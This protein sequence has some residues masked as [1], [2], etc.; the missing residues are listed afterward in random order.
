MKASAFRPSTALQRTLLATLAGAALA[1]SS[2]PALGIRIPDLDPAAIARGNAFA[3]TA[4]N[5]SA[6][7]YNPAGITQLPDQ[8][9]QLGVNLVSLSDTHTSPGGQKFDTRDQLHALPEFYYTFSSRQLPLS[10]GLGIYTPFGLGL[11][12]PDNVNFRQLALKGEMDYVTFNPVI[13]W[14]IND[15]I[16][17]GAGPMF[18]YGNTTLSQGITPPGVGPAGNRI[19][20]QGDDWNV[21]F[22][23]GVRWQ[24]NDQHAVGIVY[25]A[26]NEMNFEGTTTASLGPVPS[27]DASAKFKFPQI[28]TVGYSFRPTPHWNLEVNLD[29]TDWN[30]LNTVN[31]NQAVTGTVAR[32]FNWQ[33]SFLY[34]FGVSYLFTGNWTVSGGYIYSENSVPSEWFNPAIPDSDRHVF[35]AGV[36]KRFDRLNL[37]AAFQYAYGPT[38]TIR[39]TTIP[40]VLANGDYEFNS[41][42]L[43]LSAGY[44]F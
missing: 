32:P 44:R 30:S 17:L 40:G 33:S 7:H 16:S 29:W 31:F 39:N 10:L 41:F 1:P 8:Q 11:E 2:L 25:R 5:P 24:I 34:E 22:N 21:G 23:A 14:K 37:A 18:N 13:A 20:F 6:I 12:W 27:Q 43:S 9:V 15:R 4:D 36:S 26:E 42:S 19:E 35:S 28:I 38:R 3:A